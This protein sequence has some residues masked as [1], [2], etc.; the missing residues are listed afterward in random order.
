MYAKDTICSMDETKI[1]SSIY[2]SREDPE[3]ES[4]ISRAS[5]LLFFLSKEHNFIVPRN[6]KS[7]NETEGLSSFEV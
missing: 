7:P 2:A 1:P 3:S 5:I 4:R 6:L